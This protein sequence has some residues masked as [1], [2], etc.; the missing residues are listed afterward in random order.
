MILHPIS[1][2]FVHSYQAIYDGCY[3]CK[4]ISTVIR[5][6]KEYTCCSIEPNLK[7]KLSLYPMGLNVVVNRLN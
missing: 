3:I 7:S 4:D 5:L 6:S 2:F 1:V